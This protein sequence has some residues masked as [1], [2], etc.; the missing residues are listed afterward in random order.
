MSAR[1][2]HPLETWTQEAFGADFAAFILHGLLDDLGGGECLTSVEGVARGGLKWRKTLVMTDRE[3]GVMLQ[4]LLRDVKV[5]RVH[6]SKRRS[7][8]ARRRTSPALVY[9]FLLTF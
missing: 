6:Y 8:T 2:T 5:L 1:P 3:E 4:R 9:R 7:R